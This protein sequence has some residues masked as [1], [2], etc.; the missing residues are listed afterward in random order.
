VATT[1]KLFQRMHLHENGKVTVTCYQ[2]SHARDFLQ[3]EPY[4]SQDRST[5][6]GRIA[7]ST[8]IQVRKTAEMSFPVEL[9]VSTSIPPASSSDR[10]RFVQRHSRLSVP[11][12]KSIL[13][14]SIRRRKPLPSVRVAMELCDKSLG[15][16]LRRL[17]IIV[18]EDSTLH[19]DVPLLVWLMMA[20]SKDYDIPLTLMKRVFAIVYEMAS[21]PWRDPLT[22]TAAAPTADES[23]STPSLPLS[24]TSL[25]DLQEK[26]ESKPSIQLANNDTVLW[27]MLMRSNYGGMAG[28][29][30]MLRAYANL[31]NDRFQSSIPEPTKKRLSAS[32]REATVLLDSNWDHVPSYIHQTAAKQS[33]SRIDAILR[34]SQPGMSAWGLP[35][36]CISD[37]TIEGVDFHCSSVL[38]TSILEHSDMVQECLDCLAQMQLPSRIT[39]MPS[40]TE[41]RLGWLEDVLKSCMWNFSAGVNLRLALVVQEGGDKSVKEDKDKQ[42]MKEFWEK[43]VL[44]RT[45]AFS[46]RYVR[47]RLAS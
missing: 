27:A 31:W 43:H 44:P 12:L 1:H 34:T 16:L 21:C 23:M 8:T 32:F 39:P 46:E 17:P 47:D 4:G 3:G 9:T 42:V 10:L 24:I 15:D 7:W 26:Q 2:S 19:P 35:R 14:K 38:K 28:D 5:P 29:I 11:V 36:L 45:K 6:L 37:T 25:H 33:S 22:K 41:D 40:N 20:S 13:Q 18:L 30:R